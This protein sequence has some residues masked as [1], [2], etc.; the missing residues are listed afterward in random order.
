MS[1]KKKNLTFDMVRELLH[2]EERKNK[3]LKEYQY[4]AKD[5]I[6]WLKEKIQTLELRLDNKEKLNEEYRKEIDYRHTVNQIIPEWMWNVAEETIRDLQDRIKELKA[7]LDKYKND[8][9][10]EEW[11]YD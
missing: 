4:W 1:K 7:E 11:L 9:I 3:K 5:K 10:Y 8:I 2:Q 6:E